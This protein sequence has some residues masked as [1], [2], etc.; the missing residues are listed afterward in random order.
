MQNC[1]YDFHCPLLNE[2]KQNRFDRFSNV[3]IYKGRKIFNLESH[4]ATIRYL[5]IESRCQTFHL[6]RHSVSGKLASQEISFLSFGSNADFFINT[7]G[8]ARQSNK[9]IV[10]EATQ[11]LLPKQQRIK[12]SVD[13]SF[14]FVVKFYTLCSARGQSELKQT[15]ASF[16]LFRGC[17]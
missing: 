5:L 2:S 1:Q 6:Q 15:V 11:I 4:V 8:N 7:T 16:F 3:L 17:L 9:N 10:N 12:Q 14:C 13:Q